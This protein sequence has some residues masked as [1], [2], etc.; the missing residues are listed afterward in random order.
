MYNITMRKVL[1]KIR[2]PVHGLLIFLTSR[3][4]KK[5]RWYATITDDIYS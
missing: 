2:V 3:L 4:Q 1:V 5:N